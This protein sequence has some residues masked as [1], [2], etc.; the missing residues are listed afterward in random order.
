MDQSKET[1]TG[2]S[3]SSL[4]WDDAGWQSLGLEFFNEFAG[5]TEH[6]DPS[7]VAAASCSL[8]RPVCAASKDALLAEMKREDEEEED[9]ETNG[10]PAD[11]PTKQRKV[12]AGKAVKN[13]ASREK[14]RRE[15]INERCFL[16]PWSCQPFPQ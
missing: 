7:L 2:P 16:V 12:E 5:P 6:M 15:R 8:P 10:S 14:A 9:D 1:S 13:K 4:A 11:R 3:P